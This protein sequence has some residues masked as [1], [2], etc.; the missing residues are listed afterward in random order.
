MTRIFVVSIAGVE[1]LCSHNLPLAKQQSWA[2]CPPQV[3]NVEKTIRIAVSVGAPFSIRINFEDL[4]VHELREKGPPSEATV[5]TRTRQAQTTSAPLLPTHTPL[6]L[7]G[8][9]VGSDPG[10]R[11]RWPGSGL[12]PACP[13]CFAYASVE[14][15]IRCSHYFHPS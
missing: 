12:Q 4:F 7:T 1:T 9:A 3:S 14:R 8:T 6:P 13:P 15:L 2:M 11:P 10:C 5:V